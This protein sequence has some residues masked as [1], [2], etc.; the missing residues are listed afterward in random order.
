MNTGI[1]CINNA[2]IVR[3]KFNPD[4][5]TSNDINAKKDI[6]KI[7][8]ISGVQYTNLLIFFILKILE[9]ITI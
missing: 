8:N 7:D 9:S 4:E 5:K 1:L 6:N 2:P 3:Q